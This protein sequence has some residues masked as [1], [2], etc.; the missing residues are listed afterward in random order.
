MPQFAELFLVL[1]VLALHLH[2]AVAATNQFHDWYPEFSLPFSTILQDNCTKEYDI[3][4][5]G[6][7]TNIIDHLTGGDSDN[8]L[9]QPVVNCILSSTSEFI[10]S[11][12][13]SAQVLLGLT[14]T[15]L[16]VLGPSTEETSLLFVVG[17]RPFLALCLAAGSPA[18]F[19]LRSF[20]NKDPL[21]ILKWR[22]D[23]LRPPMVQGTR[24]RIIMILQYAFAFG[25]IANSALVSR[26]LGISVISNFAPQRTYL[27]LLWAFL[28]L[29][30]HGFGSFTLMLRVRTADELDKTGYSWLKR[31]FVL[32]N[33][34][35][36]VKLK[37]VPESYWFLFLTWFTAMGTIC[38]VIYG[39]LVFS[40]LLF[41]SVRDS[42]LVIARYMV[43]VICCRVILMYEL[44]SLR[45][46]FHYSAIESS[47]EELRADFQTKSGASD[48][49]T[50][51]RTDMSSGRTFTE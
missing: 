3:Y 14:P 5:T 9:A 19:P 38:H 27:V 18:V 47:E 34:R 33:D 44:A 1:L 24:E 7:R 37:V 48:V 2:S 16:A 25:A 49:V 29:L 20:E 45:R 22:E 41:I 51:I 26:Q 12:M 42:L 21:E 13:A 28:I 15:M 39:T 46:V 36:P 17:R 4:L 23:R 40:S 50:N 11:A 30:I 31:Q 32:V 8:Q 6:K 10:K 43:S 35:H